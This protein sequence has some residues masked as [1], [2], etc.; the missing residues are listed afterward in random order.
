MGYEGVNIRRV[1][2]DDIPDFIKQHKDIVKHKISFSNNA[3]YFGAYTVLN[4][5]LVGVFGYIEYSNK[6]K[7]KSG[8]V[9]PDFRMKGIYN[10]L[11]KHVLSILI[12]K[13]KDVY[14]NSGLMSCNSHLRNGGKILKKFKSNGFLIKYNYAKK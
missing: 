12:K 8:F 9:H 6:V 2:I 14:S 5:S 11:L 13:Q 4:D 1:S 10:L 7:L 3:K